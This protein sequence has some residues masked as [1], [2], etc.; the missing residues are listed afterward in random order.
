[1]K[2]RIINLMINFLILSMIILI[3]WMIINEDYCLE[4]VTKSLRALNIKDFSL[5]LF[6][7]IS[8]TI[9]ISVFDRFG[10]NKKITEKRIELITELLTELKKQ[11]G[12]GSSYRGGCF[13][14]P[15]FYYQKNMVK[16][17]KEIYSKI[18]GLDNLLNT[19]ILFSSNDFFNDF[20]NV[21]RVL[22][23]PLMPKSI[24]DKAQFLKESNK[25][26]GYPTTT[27]NHP[28][29]ELFLYFTLEYKE[30][31]LKDETEEWMFR[32][33]DSYT[34]KDFL[35]EF[36]VLFDACEKWTIKYSNVIEE[37]N[38]KNF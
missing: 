15:S 19:R 34:L 35:K 38:L 31:L 16:V 17:N 29:K 3:F 33:N 5:F 1:M 2:N 37:L 10:L 26:F 20:K 36:D 9:A 8:I 22:N 32:F 11:N 27:T 23:N 30:K 7:L 21:R 4:K 12:F 25:N 18:D 13:A 6:S 28:S 24:I 14:N